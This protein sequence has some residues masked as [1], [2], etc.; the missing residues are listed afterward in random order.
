MSGELNHFAREVFESYAESRPQ[1]KKLLIEA[2]KVLP[3]GDTRSVT[4]YRPFPT[5][6][7]RGEGFNIY[8]VDGNEYVDFFNNAT[9]LVLGHAHP[10][11]T[12]AVTEQVKKGSIFGSPV[13]S[14]TRLA[15][16]I[17]SRLPSVKK[18]R[19]CNSGTEATMGAVRLARAYKQ[20]YKI[21]KMEGGYN[22][23]YDLVE[24]SIKPDLEKVGPVTAPHSVPEDISVAPNAVS[25]C[26]VAPFNDSEAAE[27]IIEE[28]KDELAA[29]IVEPVLGSCGYIPADRE[30]VIKL[31]EVTK[32]NDILLIF[33]EV[34]T[35]RLS[36]GGC[37]GIYDVMP[38]ITTLGKIIGGGYPVGAI[39]GDDK[40]L[41]L[42]SP[43]NPAFLTH[44][45]TFN[46]SPVVMAAG[47]A[48]LNELTAEQIQRINGLGKN[49][50]NKLRG[51]FKEVG[52]AAQVTGMGSF[53]QVHFTKEEVKGWRQ[54][55]K[56]RKDIWP[57]LH[58]MMMERG[59]FLLPRGAFIISVPMTEN[60]IS[61][62]ASVFKSCLSDLKPYI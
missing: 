23:S 58:L 20:R 44:S 28:H 26:I 9:S 18:I 50:R 12:K 29:V 59:I 30:F 22:G 13:D 48:T 6:M 11:V 34:Q 19:F 5:F 21:V 38:D 3:G 35:F 60:Q 39:G 40:Y 17:S 47:I 43:M 25:D 36:V 24:V 31:R 2:M 7:E 61:Q 1:S 27:Q 52:I 49:L 41:D 32:R 15:N 54:V 46:G 33:D 51:V 62:A 56:A 16:I 37:Q 8:D 55:A 57:L 45:G 4:Y 42:F 53:A 10:S 14:Q